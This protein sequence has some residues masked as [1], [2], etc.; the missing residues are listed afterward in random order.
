MALRQ[1]LQIFVCFCLSRIRLL[2]ACLV[3]QPVK[4]MVACKGYGGFLY[5]SIDR[6]FF[7]YGKV[8]LNFN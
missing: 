6:Y 3:V 5:L 7:A 8:A 1:A 4:S 2:A